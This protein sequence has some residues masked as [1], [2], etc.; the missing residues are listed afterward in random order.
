MIVPVSAAATAQVVTTAP[1]AS[2]S[3]RVSGGRSERTATP[4]ATRAAP[5]ASSRPSGSTAERAQ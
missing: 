5:M 3:V 1:V 4:D 2:S